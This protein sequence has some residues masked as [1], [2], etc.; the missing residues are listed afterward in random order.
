MLNEDKLQVQRSIMQ[1]YLYFI[2]PT[3]FYNLDFELDFVENDPRKSS[4]FFPH[5]K[6]KMGFHNIDI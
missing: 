4:G 6:T 1:F 5:L 3:E 2:C